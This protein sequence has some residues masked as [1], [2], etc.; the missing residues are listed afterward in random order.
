MSGTD[1][2]PTVLDAGALALRLL[3]AVPWA[4]GAALVAAGVAALVS[5]LIPPTWQSGLRLQLVSPS[6]PLPDG[7]TWPTQAGEVQALLLGAANRAEVAKDPGARAALGGDV[8]PGAE[9]RLARSYAKQVAVFPGAG[10]TVWVVARDADP[11]RASRLAARVVETGAALARASLVAAAERAT[12]SW[13]RAAAGH[14]EEIRRLDAQLGPLAEGSR[15]RGNG[16]PPAEVEQLLAARRVRVAALEEIERRRLAVREVVEGDA[17]PWIPDPLPGSGG[18]LV[19]P[20]RFATLAGPALFAA[21]LAF[22]ARLLRDGRPAR[23]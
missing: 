14:R 8:G 5:S 6:A 1:R 19:P 18:D 15:A 13:D 12:A 2:E 9:E 22:L 7:V 23:G 11:A 20:D 4:L 10:R 21:A 3:R 17:S 16:L